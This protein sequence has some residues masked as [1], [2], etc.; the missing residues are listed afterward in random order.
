MVEFFDFLVEEFIV[1]FVVVII[2]ILGVF[3]FLLREMWFSEILFEDVMNE[4]N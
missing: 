2:V 1:D 3:I 4:L